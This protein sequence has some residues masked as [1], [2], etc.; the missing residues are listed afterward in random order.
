MHDKES[1]T[2]PPESPAALRPGRARR[3][4]FALV[5]FV[6]TSGAASAGKI[7]TTLGGIDADLKVAALAGLDLTQY[8]GRE[9]SAAQA[10]RLYERAPAQVAAALEPYS[11]Y[12][13]DVTSELK[14][15]R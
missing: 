3:L 11:Y 5:L 8:A 15:T 4:V 6:G 9:V 1:S 14:E 10:R 13:A 12:D 2:L 7:V